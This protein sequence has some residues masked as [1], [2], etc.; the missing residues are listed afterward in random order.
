[1]DALQFSVATD[2]CLGVVLLQTAQE[3]DESSPL[4]RRPCVCHLSLD[5]G[6]YAREVTEADAREI[7]LGM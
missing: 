5:D 4:L 3:G 1:M 6:R 7:I 2:V